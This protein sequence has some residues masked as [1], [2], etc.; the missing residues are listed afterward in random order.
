MGFFA[1]MACYVLTT[2]LTY[3]MWGEFFLSFWAFKGCYYFSL[4]CLAMLLHERLILKHTVGNI[5]QENGRRISICTVA[6][7]KFA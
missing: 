3:N 7:L 5:K 2:R 4:Y 6:S 1:G